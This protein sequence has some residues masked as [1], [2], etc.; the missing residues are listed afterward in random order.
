[1]H[2]K[3]DKSVLIDTDFLVVIRSFN[4]LHSPLCYS[5]REHSGILHF[6]QQVAKDAF[7][8]FYLSLCIIKS[9]PDT[10][11]YSFYEAKRT[12]KRNETGKNA[13]LNKQHFIENSLDMEYSTAGSIGYVKQRKYFIEGLPSDRTI[14]RE[15]SFSNSEYQ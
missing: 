12:T 5:Q 8:L 10:F 3:I 6:L 13:G 1:M 7:L 4:K 11:L 2:C 9:P 14:K 15:G